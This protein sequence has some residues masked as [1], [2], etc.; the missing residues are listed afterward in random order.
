MFLAEGAQAVTSALTHQPAAVHELFATTDAL[1]RHPRLGELARA[2][3]VPVSP[4]TDR[5]MAALSETATP[6]GLVAVCSYLDVAAETVAA[7]RP[8]LV[9]VLAAIR[10]PGNAGTVL[11]T[12]DAVGAGAVIVTAESVDPYNGKCVRSSAGSLFHLPVVRNAPAGASV[13]LLREAGYAILAAAG[14]GEVELAQ[15]ERTIAPGQPVAWLF[16]NEAA[17]LAPELAGAARWRVR[18]PIRGRAESFNLAAAAA[19][20]LHH[21]AQILAARGPAAPAAGPRSA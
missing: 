5:G 21:T 16:G 20:C 12:A 4:V 18:I 1:R 7:G 13:A 2:H 9:A 19:I 6:Q 8:P 14:D 3:Q 10:D 17:G 15:L 11:R